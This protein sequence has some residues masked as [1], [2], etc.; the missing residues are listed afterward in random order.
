M[1]L[2]FEY[3]LIGKDETKNGVMCGEHEWARNMN[4]D[5]LSYTIKRGIKYFVAHHNNSRIILVNPTVYTFL[6]SDQN[7]RKP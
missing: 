5:R 7:L 1:R 2:F 6:S 4:G 3:T